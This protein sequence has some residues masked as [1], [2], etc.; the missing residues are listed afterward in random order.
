MFFVRPDVPKPGMETPTTLV[1]GSLSLSAAAAEASRAS[2]LS[3][4]PDTPT[5]KPRPRMC[6]S[7]L[8]SAAACRS[9]RRESSSEA[10]AG[11]ALM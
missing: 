11:S 7:R 6:A 4:P 8:H 5:T 10:S 1:R 9:N 2:E 3:S